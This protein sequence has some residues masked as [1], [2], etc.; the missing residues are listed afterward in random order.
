MH[1]PSD[2]I[3]WIAFNKDENSAHTIPALH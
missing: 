1:A 3:S 2:V